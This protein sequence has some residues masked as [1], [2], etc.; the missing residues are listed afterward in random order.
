[1][2]LDQNIKLNNIPKADKYREWRERLR[3]IVATSSNRPKGACDWIHEVETAKDVTDLA[4]SGA[5]TQGSWDNL[6]S[7]LLEAF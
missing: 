4:D 2:D 7:A 5:G 3:G 6:D 1:M